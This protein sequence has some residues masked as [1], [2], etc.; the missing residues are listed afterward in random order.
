MRCPDCNKF[1]GLEMGDPEIEEI[2]IDE[3]GRIDATVHIVRQCAECSTDLKE[4]TL[5]MSGEIPVEIADKHKGDD[6]ELEIEGEA[7]A[8]EEGGGRYAKSYYG[9]SVNY[10]VRCS[11]QDAKDD[12]I[13]EGSL[14]EKIAASEMDEMV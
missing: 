1:V 10:T 5:E 11:C 6:C 14:D 8:I 9:A 2:E 3:D 4:A 12:P 7:E 13:Y